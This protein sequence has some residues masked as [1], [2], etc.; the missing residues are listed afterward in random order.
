MSNRF[1]QFTNTD[2]IPE[3]T[4]RFEQ[5]GE[6]TSSSDEL[7]PSISE[8]I[9]SDMYDRFDTMEEG[10]NH[11][12]ELIFNE[13][14]ALP[15]GVT[16]QELVDQGKDPTRSL[17]Q[18]IYTDPNTNRK[19][20]ILFPDRNLFGFGSK[21]TVGF[22]Q[23]LRGGVQES[24]GDAMEFGAAV[25]DKY[26]GTD[27]QEDVKDAT[28]SIDTPGFGD[29]L[30]ADG[31]PALGAALAPGTLAFK[32]AGWTLKGVKTVS[33]VG[34]F[35]INAVKSTS[36]ALTGEAAAT[37]T[38]GTE[39]GNFLF[40]EESFF[41]NVAELGD[42]EADKL[43]EQRLNTFAEGLMAG[44][45]LSTGL[46]LG[47]TGLTLT[48]DIMLAPFIRMLRGE[49]G[50]EGAV[51]KQLSRELAGLDTTVDENTL[52]ASVARL[53]EIVRAN[54]DI[55]IADFS[56]LS[57]NKTL[58]L[59]TVSAM[60]KGG[61]DPALIGNAQKIRAGEINSGGGE[62]IKQKLDAPANAVREGL[63]IEKDR[64]ADGA[65]EF[66][67]LQNSSQGFVDVAKDQVDEA[68]GGLVAA[69]TEFENAATKSL[70]S[71]E[72]DLGF[73]DALS[74][75]ETATGTEIVAPKTGAFKDIV[76]SL[77]D[78]YALMV[79]EKNNLY[80]AVRGGDVDPDSIYEL[81]SR[82]PEE[83]ITAASRNFAK[84]DPVATFLEG[85]RAQKVPDEVTDAKGNVKTVNRPETPDEIE[86]RF[87]AWISDNT[88]FGFFYTKIRPELSQLASSAYDSKAPLLGR[89]YRDLIKF[90]DQD[91]LKHV[92]DSDP[93]LAETATAAKDYYMKTYAPI[94]RDND[95]MQQFSNIYDG[96]LGRTPA[97][98]IDS[99]VSRTEP[100][101]PGFNAK[102]E[103]FTRGILNSGN[104]ARTVNLATALTDVGD[105]AKIADY[106]I[107]DTVN[108]FAN[109]VKTSGIDGADYTGFSQKLM[110]YAE[111]LNELAT[112]SPEMASKVGSINEFIRR[113]EAAG[114]DQAKVQNILDSAQKAS[115]GLMKDV[116]T[117]VL[118]N[119]FD[120][121]KTPSISKLLD[122]A[123]IKGTS[124]PQA[125]FE[126]IFGSGQKLGGESRARV[127][128]L[129]GI[130][131]EQPEANGV[132]LIR[133]LKTAYANFLDN[134]MFA[135]AEETGGTR[136]VKVKD[137]EEGVDGR[138]SI[139]DIG[140]IIYADQPQF[141]DAIRTT[142][143]AA[144]DNAQSMRATPIKGQSPT[145]FN[146][147]AAT[148]TT[149][150]IYTVVGP[151]SR[152][153][154][155]IRALMGAVV[156]RTDP[157]TAA[158]GIRKEI[159]ENSDKFLELADKY[160]KNPS[161]PLLEDLMINYISTAIIK[162]SSAADDPDEDS[163]LENMQN[164]V[165]SIAEVPLNLVK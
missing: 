51:Y 11:Y 157:D 126:T 67:V 110:R 132:I 160:N 137:I 86:E 158:A 83:D 66:D 123:Q 43:L 91:M 56:D 80:G 48:N 49:A 151:L 37:L 23:K 118:R 77:E 159:L 88:D 42:T 90:I 87:K 69:R 18:F 163:M 133:G 155:R 124:N 6:D 114:G 19:E 138:T 38:V 35:V 149:R 17:Y 119:F 107:L 152:T 31:I 96:T 52:R 3:G 162:A 25:S 121:G 136:P 85:L 94:W 16:A 112:T 27:I 76:N 13:D 93:D 116:E 70:Q 101:R 139:L 47:K 154:S 131:S 109:S 130:I 125:A 14:A 79:N 92:E 54:K 28:F 105:P 36:A 12:E 117:S 120:K 30:I 21:P 113:L 89:Y 153:G 34:N 55:L 106:F 84:S 103:E 65:T 20:T 63:A 100:F 39:E 127:A 98:A 22:S 78:S 5:F 148:A 140:D 134:R 97:N 135:V 99:T 104:M 142:I 57:K 2:T 4:N 74:R 10:Y 15:N 64:L 145:S 53:T 111:Q 141:M 62:G 143:E 1:E 29:S 144:G 40:G 75:L 8:G 7:I 72:G 102:A 122:S 95:S 58:T 147:E 161:D 9:N 32:V 165:K 108:G 33:K 73:V 82:M 26:F 164:N 68:A 146:R 129:M 61:M 128:E 156:E 50:V 41:N 24:V 115:E 59:D 44:G 46:K 71:M 45:V 81:F 150:L 60:Q